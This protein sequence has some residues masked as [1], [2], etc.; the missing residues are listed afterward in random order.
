MKKRLA[1]I[2][3]VFVVIIGIIIKDTYLIAYAQE[4]LNENDYKEL[5][6]EKVQELFLLKKQIKKEAHE[7]KNNMELYEKEVL[8]IINEF[9]EKKKD[10]DLI[11]NEYNKQK[12]ELEMYKSKWM[13]VSIVVVA[14]V[15]SIGYLMSK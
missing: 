7:L 2:L 4:L 9:N 3:L 12:V 1:W 10:Y 8:K 13:G 11:L 14:V 5:Y 6:F 15:V